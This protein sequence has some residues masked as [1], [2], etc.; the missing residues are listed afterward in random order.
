[1]SVLYS[2]MTAALLFIVG[3][4]MYAMF[5]AAL[6]VLATSL[7]ATGILQIFLIALHR[8]RKSYVRFSAVELSI[9]FVLTFLVITMVQNVA[10]IILN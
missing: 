6:P 5:D 2:I 7:V 4:T 10:I 3:S 8:S 1:M 9:I